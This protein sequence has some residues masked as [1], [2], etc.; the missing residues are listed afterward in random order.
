MC[1]KESSHPA[2]SE[3]PER[4]APVVPQELALVLK[5]LA[6]ELAQPPGQALVQ[7]QELPQLE[8]LEPV[9]ARTL[10]PAFSLLEMAPEELGLPLLLAER[11]GPQALPA[12]PELPGWQAAPPVVNRTQPIEI[13]GPGPSG[14]SEFFRSCF[15]LTK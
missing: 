14:L 2:S 15:H 8:V 13:Q 5:Q 10:L 12:Q 4:A 6:L 9:R 3:A 11:A 7:E 1:P